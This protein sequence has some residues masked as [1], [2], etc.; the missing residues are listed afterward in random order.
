MNLLEHH[1]L[2]VLEENKYGDYVTVKIKI[3]CYGVKEITE[4]TT[5]IKQWEKEK[6]QGYFLA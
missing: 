2:E 6:K 5:T 3:D 4:H 1:I